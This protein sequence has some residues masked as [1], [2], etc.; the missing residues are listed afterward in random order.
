MN[1]A[2]RKELKRAVALAEEVKVNLDLIEEILGTCSEEEQE[3]FDNLP[4]SLQDG[5][6]GGMMQ[7][8]IECLDDAVSDIGGIRDDVDSLIDKIEDAIE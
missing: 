6:K 2:R 1:N 7:E 3:C 5:D 8:A 4:E